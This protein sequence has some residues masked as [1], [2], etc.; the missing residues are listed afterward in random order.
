MKTLQEKIAVMQAAAEGKQIQSMIPDCSN[1]VDTNNPSWDWST[2]DYRVK[3]EQK[4]KTLR[5]YTFE[6]AKGL[7][8]EKVMS[9]DKNHI[10]TITGVLTMGCEVFIETGPYRIITEIIYNKYTFL[11]GTPCGVEE[12]GE[13]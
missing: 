4:P 2:F 1:W 11:D 7:L 8:G 12:G 10:A 6:E 3:P 13:E 9:K 5:P